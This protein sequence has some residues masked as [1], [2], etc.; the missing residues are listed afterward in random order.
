[1]KLSEVTNE[2]SP[3]QET[4]YSINIEKETIDNTDYRRVL[5]TSPNNQ[6]VIMNMPPSDELGMETHNDTAQFIRIE[7]GTGRAIV[8]GK[9][10]DL[11]DGSVIIVPKGIEHNIVNTSDT[12]EMKLYTVYSP[13]VH[14]DGEVQK[15]KQDAAKGE[16][17]HE[18]A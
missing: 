4:G 1:M 7:R 10:Y 15:T 8:G 9:V 6:L 17:E 12:D 14:N 13:G 5:F 18:A 11:T 2:L 3:Q 16:A